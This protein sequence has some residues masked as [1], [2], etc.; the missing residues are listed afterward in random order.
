MIQE[1][2]NLFH[3]DFGF[4]LGNFLKVE[5]KELF[6]PFF[7]F[8]TLFPQFAGIERETTPFVLTR[9]MVYVMGGQGSPTYKEFTVTFHSIFPS[10]F[11]LV[12]I[13]FSL[14]PEFVL[15]CI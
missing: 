9:E 5:R 6:F 12:F 15:H 3:I 1:T 14:S 7:S 11:L 13:F 4:I 2:G 8:L 10:S